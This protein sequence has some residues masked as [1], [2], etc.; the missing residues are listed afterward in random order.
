MSGWN[1]RAG[2]YN[3]DDAM[4]GFGDGMAGYIAHEYC[5]AY[6]PEEVDIMRRE[7]HD[8]R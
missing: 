2:I 6:R 4:R 3:R 5:K 8:A 1:S 7:S